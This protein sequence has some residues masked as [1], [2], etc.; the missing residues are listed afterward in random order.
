MLPCHRKSEH[1]LFRR[2]SNQ[3]TIENHTVTNRLTNK[4]L[5]QGV[6]ELSATD[7][8]L[9]RVVELYGP[10]PMWGRKAGFP[11]LVKIILEQQV[12]LVS[13]EAVFRKLQSSVS[14]VSPEQIKK[15]S[16]SGLREIGFTRQKAG[17]CEGL[18]ELILAGELSLDS[19]KRLDDESAHNKLLAIKGIG[20]WT[21][22][23]YLLMALRRPD[24]WPDGDLA[25]AESARRIKKLKERPSYE[26]LN[27]MAQNWRPWRSVA[28][29]IL[30][31]AYLS[32]NALIGTQ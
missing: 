20:P 11:A 29:R 6:A 16:V 25:L 14:D 4:L 30:W 18:A 31:H 26:R 17:Y 22:N 27:K 13:A 19:L 2:S 9:G 5:L 8:G 21:A 23:I 1:D 28:A 12:S 32:E 3:C 7:K 10:P 24:V 15:L